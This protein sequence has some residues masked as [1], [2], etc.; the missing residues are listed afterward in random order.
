M[1]AVVITAGF[2]QKTTGAHTHW[3]CSGWVVRCAWFSVV[4]RRIGAP[5]TDHQYVEPPLGNLRLFVSVSRDRR[6]AV[7]LALSLARSTVLVL[8]PS[9]F[10][11]SLMPV[12]FLSRARMLACLSLSMPRPL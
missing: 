7:V 9:S 4:L 5:W 8:T 10:A 3:L 12:P 1:R 11:V 2:E 6:Q